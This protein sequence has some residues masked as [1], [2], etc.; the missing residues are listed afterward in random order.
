MK[1]GE[2]GEGVHDEDALRLNVCQL[3]EWWYL[4]DE[5]RK[6]ETILTNPGMHMLLTCFDEL[7]VG[8]FQSKGC[9]EISSTTL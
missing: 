5:H 3:I 8:I 6:N 2:G 4:K 9:L 7:T 1:T